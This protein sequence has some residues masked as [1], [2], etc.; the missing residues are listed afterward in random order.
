MS[1]GLRLRLVSWNLHGL[2][3]PTRFGASQ[4]V[5]RAA[6][7]ACGRNPDIILFQEVWRRS[8][9]DRL[10]T[11]CTDYDAAIPR[12]GGPGTGG[13]VTLFCRAN[14]TLVES[15]FTPFDA[16]ASPLRIWEGDGLS[17]KGVLT[18]RMTHRTTGASIA[19]I[20]THFQSQYGKRTY[21]RVRQA[22][23]EQL[24]RIAAGL[25]TKVDTLF[26]CGD[27]NT[28]P[29][30]PLYA[31]LQKD[32]LD[33]TAQARADCAGRPLCGT[34]YQTETQRIWLDYIFLRGGH[35]SVHTELTMIRNRSKDNPFSDH[36]GV[37]AVVSFPPTEARGSRLLR[38][39]TVDGSKS[40]V[41][42]RLAIRSLCRVLL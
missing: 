12:Q 3:P 32:W 27:L 2:P 29:D 19:V 9:A 34:Y 5:L 23:A 4:R 40:S 26:L 1:G 10:L 41:S 39:M 14:W 20:N 33:L 8:Y 37:E 25:D 42:R 15:A 16:H 22:Q 6:D 17:R 35:P 28:T 30:E 13:L 11:R 18:S 24:N 38:L 7:E 21:L 36:D 31:A